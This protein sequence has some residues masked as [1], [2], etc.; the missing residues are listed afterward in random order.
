MSASAAASSA[1]KAPE[2]SGK[3]TSQEEEAAS[4]REAS[5]LTSAP[6][7]EPTETPTEK[8]LRH[9][10]NV[11]VAAFIIWIAGAVAGSITWAVVVAH[12]HSVAQQRACSNSGGVYVYGQCLP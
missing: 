1:L 10:R 8:Y 2:V 3:G 6:T 9:I 11:V 12:D 5:G 4:V 7:S